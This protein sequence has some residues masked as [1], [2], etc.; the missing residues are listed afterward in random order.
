MQIQPA[1]D[2]MEAAFGDRIEWSVTFI[3]TPDS[4]ALRYRT[5]IRLQVRTKDNQV[6]TYNVYL[7]MMWE[8]DLRHAVRKL[9]M[10]AD[11]D[12]AAVQDRLDRIEAASR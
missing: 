4:P 7:T 9:A 2:A 5:R 11:F 8:F 10:C 12:I 6:W 3:S 1:Y